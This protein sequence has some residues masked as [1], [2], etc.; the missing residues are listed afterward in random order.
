M[1]VKFIAGVGLIV[2][3]GLLSNSFAQEV[4]YEIDKNCNRQRVPQAGSDAQM[5]RCELLS[6]T[7][8]YLDDQNLNDPSHQELKTALANSGI[9]PQTEAICWGLPFGTL[10][11]VFSQVWHLK[12][13]QSEL[14]CPSLTPRLELNEKRY[15]TEWEAE[16]RKNC[17]ARISSDFDTFITV[18]LDARRNP[19]A[20]RISTGTDGVLPQS[21]LVDNNH[22]QSK[23]SS[24]AIDGQEAE[25]ALTEMVNG[26]FV[27]NIPYDRTVSLGKFALVVGE[28]IS[29]MSDCPAGVIELQL[30]NNNSST[31]EED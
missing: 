14:E 16:E 17:Y 6:A 13:Y 31:L 7:L 19:V 12:A 25:R 8:K 27:K 10:G 9:N 11:G 20:I 30:E 28:E 21:I 15:E 22:F 18:E 29:L 1:V 3:S 24:Y 4:G 26:E 2:F 23:S 5:H